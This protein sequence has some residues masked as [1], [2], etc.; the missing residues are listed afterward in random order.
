M[1]RKLLKAPVCNDLAEP[2]SQS[3][4]TVIQENTQSLGGRNRML[5]ENR[6]SFLFRSLVEPLTTELAWIFEVVTVREG[7]IFLGLS[8][9]IKSCVLQSY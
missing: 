4:G 3:K 8:E 2:R 5:R 7:E 1:V 6:D 9:K